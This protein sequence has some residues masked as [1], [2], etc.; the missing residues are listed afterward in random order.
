MPFKPG[1][2]GNPK[3]RPRDQAKRDILRARIKG[4][5]LVDALEAHVLEE[6]P[7]SP[8]QVTAAIALL[9]KFL[10]DLNHC[11]M[12]G[13]GGGPVQIIFR[14]FGDADPNPPS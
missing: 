11:E 14:S 7:L 6:R 10:P 13:D 8:T 1:H 4:P 12:A 5:E 3:G 2:S 9:K